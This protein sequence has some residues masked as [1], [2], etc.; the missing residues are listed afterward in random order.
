[1]TMP[2]RATPIPTT[3]AVAWEGHCA[4]HVLVMDDR[5]DILHLLQ[6]LLTE[7]GYRV[8]TSPALLDPAAVKALAPDVIVLD[9]R[10]GP[11]EEPAWELLTLAH[12][13]E[14]LPRIPFV[15]CTAAAA[16]VNDPSAAQRL[17][18]LGV[19]VVLKPF[20]V[21]DLL[22]AIDAQLARARRS[23]LAWR[24]PASG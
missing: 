15:L 8:S 2:P 6:E 21:D 22:A 1:M 17:A 10:F 20:D 24:K 3:D 13:G 23:T 18:A 12:H 16:T 7:E 4:P 14:D 9:L 5:P 11:S 19:P